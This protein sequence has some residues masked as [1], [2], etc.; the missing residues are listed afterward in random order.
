MSYFLDFGISKEITERKFI[1]GDTLISSECVAGTPLYMSPELKE[2]YRNNISGILHDPFKSDIY[3]L[4]LIL[5]ETYLIKI[6]YENIKQI[7][8]NPEE[9][10]KLTSTLNLNRFILHEHD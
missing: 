4:G 9:V 3:S 6:K 8:V 1:V 2:A 10:S 5:L 7:L